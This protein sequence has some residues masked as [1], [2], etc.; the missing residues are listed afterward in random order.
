[1]RSTNRRQFIVRAAAIGGAAVL[2]AREAVAAAKPGG[3]EGSAD[4]PLAPPDKQPARLPV[5]DPAVRKAGWAIVGLGE[6]ALG[7]I[8][9]AF[10]EARLS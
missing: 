10:A 5:P 2:G 4:V 9:P 1:M 7:E 3:A 6:L 8:M